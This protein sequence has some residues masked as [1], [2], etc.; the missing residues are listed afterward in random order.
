MLQNIKFVITSG[1]K[2]ISPVIL[3]VI[4]SRSGCIT[5]NKGNDSNLKSGVNVPLPEQHLSQYLK[6]SY[7]LRRTNCKYSQPSESSTQ[8]SQSG[9]KRKFDPQAKT[10]AA[11]VHTS[12]KHNSNNNT[13]L[14]MNV[15]NIHHRRR[16]ECVT[17]RGG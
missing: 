17:N 14:T 11:Q 8:K 6:S 1:D 13:Q 7:F 12:H 16:E 10:Q 4:L 5:G 2:E 3:S 15:V 9:M